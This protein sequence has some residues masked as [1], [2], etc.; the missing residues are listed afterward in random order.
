MNQRLKPLN[1]ILK[2]RGESLDINP[3]YDF[4]GYDTKNTNNKSKNQHPGLYQT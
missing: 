1:S 3:G 2:H 4:Y